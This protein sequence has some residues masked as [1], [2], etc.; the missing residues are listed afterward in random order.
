MAMTTVTKKV[1]AIP[2]TKRYNQ[3][4]FVYVPC[5]ED[6]TAFADVWRDVNISSSLFRSRNFVKNYILRVKRRHAMKIHECLTFIRV[7]L[8]VPSKV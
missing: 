3:K 2:A 1:G 4:S 7:Y 6:C 8:F 5:G